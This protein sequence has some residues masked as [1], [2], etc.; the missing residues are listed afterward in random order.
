[1]E[2]AVAP[3]SERFLVV[4]P[5]SGAILRL[6]SATLRSLSSASSIAIENALERQE[7][8]HHRNSNRTRHAV[9]AEV[10]PTPEGELS[11]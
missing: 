2:A 1:V 7:S 4:Q 10:P 3:C 11:E 9:D 8:G 6:D 5:T